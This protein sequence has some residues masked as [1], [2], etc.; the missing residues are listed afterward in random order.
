MI[1]CTSVGMILLGSWWW[2]TAAAFILRWQ[3]GMPHVRQ[4]G[5]S[6]LLLVLSL[7]AAVGIRPFQWL[8]A[9]LT[10]KEPR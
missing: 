4:L 7:H 6:M 10:P 5:F 8:N 1:L 9:W 3:V 2:C